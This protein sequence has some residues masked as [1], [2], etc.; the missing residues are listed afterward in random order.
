MVNGTRLKAKDEEFVELLT[1]SVCLAPAGFN[2]KT[3][4]VNS[5]GS[6]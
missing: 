2:K 6:V 3:I 1:S 5:E 4:S